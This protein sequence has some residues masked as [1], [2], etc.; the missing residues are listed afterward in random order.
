MVNCGSRSELSC[1]RKAVPEE[2]EVI[3]SKPKNWDL[4]LFQNPASSKIGI[5]MIAA[6]K[7]EA[8]T[9]EVRDAPGRLVK[10]KSA[11]ASDFDLDCGELSDG[12]YSVR[13]S[14]KGNSKAQT[15]VIRK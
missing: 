1:V 12:L 11:T 13:V 2:K 5:Q 3:T 4:N 8:I 14:Q 15:L 10:S 7:N 9:I 6:E